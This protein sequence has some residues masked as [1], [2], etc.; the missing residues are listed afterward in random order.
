[1]KLAGPAALSF[2]DKP[3]AGVRA[4][5]IFGADAG[6]VSAAADQLAKTWL[7]DP[8]PM[9]VIRLSDD[10]LRRDPRQLADELVARSLLGGERLVRV[11]AERDGSSKALLE[12][13]GDIESGAI[14]AEAAWIVEA[15]DLNRTN[16]LRAG[17][18][19]ARLAAALQLYAEDEGAIAAFV[20]ARLKA[21]GVALEP[22]A[23]Q[24]F[25]ADLPGD[26]RL[27]TSEVEKLELY[28]LDLG[29]AVTLGDIAA[30]APAEQPRGA[31]DAADAAILGDVAGADR[32][33]DRFLDAGGNAISAL[34]TLHFRLLR[35]TDASTGSAG[36]RLRPPIFDR[37]W[38][39]YAR[40][41]RD[42]PPRKIH[43]AFAELYAAEKT[44]KQAGAPTEPVVRRLLERIALRDV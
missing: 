38:P 43:A 5:L 34:R 11:R 15:G 24:A 1:M 40:A 8:D 2:C 3:R 12:T 42:W 10:D 28:A 6:L 41:M 31:D 33:I 32:A 44:C 23:M 18:E 16:K 26:R 29:R 22:N 20:S 25:C 30:I 35:L 7:P 39:D 37:D 4:A 19:A 14:L 9:N 13:L 36:P 27:A 21:A 17:F